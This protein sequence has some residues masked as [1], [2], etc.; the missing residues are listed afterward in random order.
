MI[1]IVRVGCWL[2]DDDDD[3]GTGLLCEGHVLVQ[4]SVVGMSGWCWHWLTSAA[5]HHLNHHEDH[6]PGPCHHHSSERWP[7]RL[8]G[9]QGGG[10][11]GEGDVACLLYSHSSG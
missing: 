7:H 10:N 8:Q 4:V 2:E 9:G 3:D 1:N 11:C 6:P 5:V